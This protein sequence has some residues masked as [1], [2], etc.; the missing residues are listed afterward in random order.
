MDTRSY[1]A[2]A[3]VIKRINYGEA[4]RIITLFT[5]EHGKI[6]VIA[7][8]VRKPTS[9]RRG[10]IELFNHIQAQVIQTKGL[11]IL[12]HVEAIEYF[13]DI[14]T[15]FPNCHDAFARINTAYHLTEIVDKLLPEHQSAPL[16][17]DWLRNA[18]AHLHTQAPN[19][20]HLHRS[21]KLRLLQELGF[22]PDDNQPPSDIDAYLE[23]VLERPLQTTPWVASAFA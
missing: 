16:I 7:K 21:F 4:D 14:P 2:S 20:D 12:T 15:K 18:Y 11:H 22:W 3:I 9:R 17:F 13:A 1:T 10:H 8:G 23:T 19:Y 6:A 5:R